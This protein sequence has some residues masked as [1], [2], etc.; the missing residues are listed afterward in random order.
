MS[1][2][3]HPETGTPVSE[4]PR[5]LFTRRGRAIDIDV[6]HAIPTA[7][8]VDDAIYHETNYHPSQ[9]RTA[10]D[11][12]RLYN[13]AG[14]AWASRRFHVMADWPNV[15]R[16]LDDD[17][18]RPIEVR[19]VRLGDLLLYVGNYRAPNQCLDHVAVVSRIDESS[20]LEQSSR[21]RKIWV[22]SKFGDASG[23]TIHL[24]DHI[25]K[26]LT[27]STPL[28]YTERPIHEPTLMRR[29]I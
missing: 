24:H 10:V 21:L 3:F 16:I 13:C 6:S 9:R 26:L 22:L 2:R 5:L 17:G 11:L 19:D 15:Q 25:P 18:Y 8:L 28:F 7:Q 14:L 20:N 29:F 12:T 23:E 4:S 27:T 1:S